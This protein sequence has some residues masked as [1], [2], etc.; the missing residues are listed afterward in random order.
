MKHVR[1]YLYT[2]K[3]IWVVSSSPNIK[4]LFRV[5]CINGA[6]CFGFLKRHPSTENYPH[7]FKVCTHMGGCQNYG[8]FLGSLL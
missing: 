1:V 6:D 3:H 4:V 8:P 5:L 2:P 7:V